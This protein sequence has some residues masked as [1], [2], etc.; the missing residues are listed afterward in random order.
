MSTDNT[1]PRKQESSFKVLCDDFW[2][3]VSKHNGVGG[4]ALTLL[5]FAGLALT[6]WFIIFSG[7][8]SSA[9]F[10]YSQF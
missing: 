9:D 2:E 8:S 5:V 4:I 6:F 3:F 7:L 10:I 1:K